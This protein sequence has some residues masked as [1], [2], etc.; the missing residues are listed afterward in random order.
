MFIVH[1]PSRR[2][3]EKES[4]F[5]RLFVAKTL[6]H[7]S[8]SVEKADPACKILVMGDFND[9]PNNKSLEEELMAKK[10]SNNLPKTAFYNPMF[11]LMEK[12]GGSYRHK[13]EWNFLDQM[14]LNQKLLSPK[15]KLVYEDNSA[16]VFVKDWM[17]ETEEKYKGNP[18][19]TF[20]GTKYLN[21]YSDHLPV[22]LYLDMK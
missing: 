20:G 16:S 8:D 18:L 9:Y 6:K 7:I 5:K 21:G 14:L 13:G 17:L 12:G 2:E 22:Y 19:R 1:F 15:S 11:A 4:E 3:G 10:T